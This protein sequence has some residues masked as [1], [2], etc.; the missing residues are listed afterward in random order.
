MCL[1]KMTSYHRHL[2]KHLFKHPNIIC[3]ESCGKFLLW[4]PFR[5][6]CDAQLKYSTLSFEKLNII[7][8]GLLICSDIRILV[9]ERIYIR[10]MKNIWHRFPFG[11][12]SHDCTGLICILFNM[13]YISFPLPHRLWAENDRR[14][15]LIMQR[16][17]FR[18]ESESLDKYADI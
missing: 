16:F 5:Y 3:N 4:W 1:K 17:A 14:V 9:F 10:S 2:I 8:N 7:F 18:R 12:P 6:P 11:D 15:I 13:L